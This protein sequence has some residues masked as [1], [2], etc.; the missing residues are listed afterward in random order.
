MQDEIVFARTRY[1]YDSYTDFWRL[2]E[3]SGYRTVYVDEIDLGSSGV[4]YISSPFNGEFFPLAEQKK[5]KSKLLLWNLERPA[6]SGGVDEYKAHLGEHIQNGYIDG[7]IVS[8]TA[9]A[10][11]TG[12][13]YVPMGSHPDLG[14]P[15]TTKS[16]AF[17]HLMCYAPRRSLL[18]NTPSDPK[19]QYGGL[20]IASNGWGEERHQGL[21]K[22]WFML[23]VHQDE[24]NFMEPLR[25]SLAIAYGLPI[26]SENLYAPPFPYHNATIQFP[27]EHLGVAMMSAFKRRRGLSEESYKARKFV[28][29]YHSFRDCIDRSLM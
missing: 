27:L 15:G 21:Q 29:N 1:V 6:A 24:M 22:S 10:K 12:F 23:N 2:I 9:L 18:F 5:R 11:A 7:V 25:F 28:M 3:L 14:V 26:L 8:Y 17:I 13:T 16:Y 20:T 4:T 19:V